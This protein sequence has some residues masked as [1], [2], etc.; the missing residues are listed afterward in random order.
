MS[1]T[2]KADEI[3]DAFLD[4]LRAQGM[5]VDTLE[6]VA[7]EATEQ[8]L[9][10]VF[11]RLGRAGREIYVVRGVGLINIHIRSTAP[12]WWN[13]LKS[14]KADFD[15][16]AKAIGG[17]TFYVLL[18]GRKDPKDI[19][20]ANGWV[21]TDFLS[22]PFLQPPSEEATKYTVKEGQH[23]DKGKLNLSVTKV[24]QKLLQMGAEPPTMNQQ[25]AQ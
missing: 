11:R 21:A 19:H 23:L 7:A 9:R 6:E 13:I 10:D 17:K 15:A 20:V 24:A 16:L 22:S 1:R 12:G 14:V 18:V 2:D 5:R 3:R 8:V 4:A 25:I